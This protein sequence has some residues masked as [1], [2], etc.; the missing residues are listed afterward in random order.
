MIRNNVYDVFQVFDF[1]EPSLPSSQRAETTVAPQA[2][3]LLNGPFVRIRP[4][5]WPSNC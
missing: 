5:C 1:V 4:R 2:L 3:F